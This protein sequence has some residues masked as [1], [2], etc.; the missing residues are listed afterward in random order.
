MGLAQSP[1]P[2][3]W[4]DRLAPIFRKPAELSPH[5]WAS[6][7]T[8]WSMPDPGWPNQYQEPWSV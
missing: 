4:P 5:H 8:R 2:W 1:Y 7:G 3:S 6:L